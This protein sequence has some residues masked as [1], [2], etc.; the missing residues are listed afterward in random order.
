MSLT[1]QEVEQVESALDALDA[2]STEMAVMK[3]LNAD[4]LD[5]LRVA[6]EALALAT[7]AKQDRAFTLVRHAIAEAL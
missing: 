2:L 5:A 4:L 7:N 3:T 6:E 1:A